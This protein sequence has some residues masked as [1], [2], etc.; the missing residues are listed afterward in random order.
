MARHV[1]R[2][3]AAILDRATAKGYRTGD[4]PASLK[5]PLGV[6]LHA[7]DKVHKHKVHPWLPFEQIGAFM[8]QLRAYRSPQGTISIPAKLLEFTILTAV[9]S[10]QAQLM[11]R[12]E[13]DWDKKLWTCPWQR[14][15]TGGNNQE[16][17]LVPLSAPALAVLKE[18]QAMQANQGINTEFVFTGARLDRI[19]KP[20][21]GKATKI[22]LR[23]VLKPTLGTNAGFTTHGFRRTFSTWANEHGFPREAI[24]MA[25]DHEFGSAMERRYNHA[26]LLDQRRR[27]MDAWGEFCGR[28]QPLPAEVV[29]FRQTK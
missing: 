13:I 23:T 25:L 5:G 4:N 15:K 16:D 3:C 29:P 17:H 28:T 21:A 19:G 9:R 24:E 18:M 14:T 7:P 10:H 11:E 27:L 6:L 22:F 1:R 26:K 8:A 20:L 12:K 2:H